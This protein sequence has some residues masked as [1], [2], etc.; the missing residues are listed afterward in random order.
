MSYDNPRIKSLDMSPMEIMVSFAEGNP[1][2]ITVLMKLLTE[3]EK[4]DPDSMLGG[5][6]PL[7]SLDNMD[8]YGSRIWMFYK[9]VCKQDINKMMAVMRAVQLG[10]TSDKK[11]AAAIDG[12]KEAI[13]VAALVAQVKERLPDFK[14]EAHA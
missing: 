14:V 6:G 11:V 1:G 3:A 7:F 2:A 13:D 12:D 9:D 8:V 10:F 4:I 5:M